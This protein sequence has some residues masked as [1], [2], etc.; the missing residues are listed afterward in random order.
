MMRA[1]IKHWQP[2]DCKS[3]I[4]AK[5]AFVQLISALEG[6]YLNGGKLGNQVGDGMDIT[7]ST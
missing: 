5:L 1:F 4:R 6:L 3:W 2:L 7:K